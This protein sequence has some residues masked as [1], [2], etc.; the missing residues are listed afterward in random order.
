MNKRKFVEITN[1]VSKRIKYVPKNRP[2]VSGTAIR[3]YLL[4]DP[5]VDWLNLPS[6]STKTKPIFKKQNT[7]L[8]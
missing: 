4:K 3:N 1:A 2:F 5:V 8:R 6:L 7:N